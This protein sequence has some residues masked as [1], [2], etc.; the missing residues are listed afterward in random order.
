MTWI[1]I[2]GVLFIIAF[3]AIF[4]LI[5]MFKRCERIEAVSESKD[6]IIIAM[7]NRVKTIDARIRDIDYRGHF[8][9]DDEVGFFFNE[10]KEM[11]DSL[12]EFVE[13][14]E[15]TI[16]DAEKKTN[17]PIIRSNQVKKPE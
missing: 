5:N 13:I 3:L 15:V 11:T 9:A 17:Q 14:E 7:I 6:D 12:M 10:M 8:E 4:G 16:E 2:S 1:I